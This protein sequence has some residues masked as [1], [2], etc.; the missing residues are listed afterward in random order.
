MEFT[1]HYLTKKKVDF[2]APKE[3]WNPLNK[4]VLSKCSF[5]SNNGPVNI[6]NDHKARSNLYIGPVNSFPNFDT[7]TLYPHLSK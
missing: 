4:V 3:L 1:S 7:A 5:I 6:W 2:K